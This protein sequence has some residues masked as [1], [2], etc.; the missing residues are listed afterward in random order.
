M[1]VSN[2]LIKK[3]ILFGIKF[4]CISITHNPN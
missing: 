2:V 1:Y 4:V 3:N